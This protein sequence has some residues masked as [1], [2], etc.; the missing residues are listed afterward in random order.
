MD[1]NTRHVLIEYLVQRA[2]IDKTRLFETILDNLPQDKETT[3]TVAQQLEQQGRQ[4]SRLEIA[5][6][7]L[8]EGDAAE[9]VARVTGLDKKIIINLKKDIKD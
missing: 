2:D 8:N 1:D 3:M 5:R 7:M 9:K 4:Q 6:N